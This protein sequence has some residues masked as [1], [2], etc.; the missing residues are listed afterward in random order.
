MRN[1]TNISLVWYGDHLRHGCRNV[2]TDI[3]LVWQVANLHSAGYVSTDISLVWLVIDLHIG[4]V[5]TTICLI[6]QVVHLHFGCIYVT[7]DFSSVWH[8]DRSSSW[9]HMSRLTM[10]TFGRWE[11]FT[12][13]VYVT[14][15][16]CFRLAW[17][18]SSLWLYMTRLD[19]DHIWQ[20]GDLH[21][22]CIKSLQ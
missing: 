8:G 20:V 16:I 5:T 1:T 7:T 14:A 12:L 22:G 18:R 10:I 21:S 17:G 15:A 11:I 13:A 19:S 6:W 2:L 3:S 9:L 4:Y